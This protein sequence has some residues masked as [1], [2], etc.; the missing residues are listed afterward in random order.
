METKIESVTNIYK[1]GKL[2]ATIK[3]DDVLKKHCIYMT[4][5]AKTEDIVKLITNDIQ[6]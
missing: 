2:I 5:E 4:R 3:R 1:N 6:E